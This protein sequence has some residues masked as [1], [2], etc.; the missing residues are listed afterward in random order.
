MSRRLVLNA[1]FA[2]SGHHPAAWRV[3]GHASGDLDAAWYQEL[4]R[5]AE[6]GKLQSIFFA[7]G[8][9]HQASQFGPTHGVPEPRILLTT[10]A[11]AT[12]NIGLIATSSTTYNHP[13]TLAREFASLDTVS[14]G[15]A[16]W[17]VVT[18]GH[19]AAAANYGGALPTHAERYAIADEFLRVT[20]GLWASWDEDPRR[21]GGI[22]PI[23]H[24]GEHFSVTGPL[25]LGRSP[26]G[27][28]VVV[29]A[30]SSEAGIALAGKYAE[31]VFTATP[32]IE[33]G[34]EYYA[35][36]K[37]AVAEAGRNPE[38]TKVLPGLMPFVAETEEE[39]RALK[40][41]Y[42]AAIDFDAGLVALGHFFGGVDLSGH[43]LDAPVP[44]DALPTAEESDGIKSRIEI[45]RRIADEGNLSLRGLV[46]VIANGRGHLNFV[47][48][49]VQVAD[50]IEEWFTTGAADGFNLLIPAYPVLLEDFIDN[51]VPILQER[52]LFHTEYEG[53]TLRENYGLPIPTSEG[54][55]KELARLG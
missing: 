37:A 31:A 45:L 24:V 8:P 25:T 41:T 36:L 6:R 46:E 1:F 55:L 10:I 48:S 44:F 4:A 23:D 54:T 42:D 53:T 22:R 32:T 9:A 20:L 16:A 13:Y 40:A 15:R 33:Q 52:G 17:N 47:G 43:D 34:R 7:D 2:G 11:A 39:A 26:Q 19:E 27:H 3:L 12:S 29:Q 18:T 21:E 49:Y 51:V 14:G 38:H 35:K 50:F 5:T 30:G 28:P